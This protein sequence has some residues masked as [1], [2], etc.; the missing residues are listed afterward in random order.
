MR[1]ATQSRAHAAVLVL[2]GGLIAGALDI[3][4]ACVFWALKAGVSATRIFQ[5]VAAGLVGKASFEGGGRTAALGLGLHFFIA[6]SMSVAYYVVA[7]RWSVLVRRPVLC[8]VAY[9]I[10]LYVLMN[11]VVVP[12]SAA[13][14][15]SRDPWWIVLTIVVHMFLIGLP[16]G[17][18]SGRAA[19]E[20]NQ[21]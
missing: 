16:I 17:L 1:S 4:Y 20:A 5:S 10:L 11:Y 12:L 14:Q 2:S 9:G 6:G 15:G 18:L 21:P 3:G 8:G 19:A 13:P 7:R